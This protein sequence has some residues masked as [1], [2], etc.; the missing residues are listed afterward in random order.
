MPTEPSMPRRPPT[1]CNA[2][3]SRF[4]CGTSAATGSRGHDE[5]GAG[6][7]TAARRRFV[8]LATQ[9][10]GL[11]ATM[12]S[13][14]WSTDQPLTESS[15]MS[16]STKND[17]DF[18]FGR[19]RVHHRRLR[20]WLVGSDEWLEF[21]GTSVAQP[22]LDGWGNIDDNVL[23][24]PAGAYRATTL[25][26]FDPRTKKWAIWWLDARNPH[27]SLDPPMVG[28]FDDGV[29]TFY[30]EDTFKGRPIRAR[31]LW[32]KTN[33]SSPHWEQAFSLDE[34]KTWEINWMNYFVRVADAS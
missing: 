6:A 30:A 11:A 16:Q 17:F 7:E 25:R 28:T 10:L 8:V 4:D 27:A 33:T 21:D 32:T 1:C 31:F 26:A 22:I 13:L 12:S 5:Y 34:G 15:A 14:A 19:W 2:A 24:L 29:G 20:D 3:M 18:L 23:N 9:I